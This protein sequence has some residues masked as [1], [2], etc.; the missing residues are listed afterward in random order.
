MPLLFKDR[1]IS[2]GKK[3]KQQNV[4]IYS[5]NP[6]EVFSANVSLFWYTLLLIVI[7][8]L[9]NIIGIIYYINKVHCET[10]NARNKLK[11]GVS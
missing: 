3:K 2:T 4:L 5:N 6:G 11:R 9:L 7:F 8:L 10:N 1:K